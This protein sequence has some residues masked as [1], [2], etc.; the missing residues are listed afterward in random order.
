MIKKYLEYIK[1][2]KEEKDFSGKYQELKDKV[3]SFIQDTVDEE[4][5]Y[6]SVD[7]FIDSYVKKEDIDIR[8]LIKQDDL[9]QFYLDWRNDID[10]ILNSINFFDEV[11]SKL[12]SIGL[13]DYIITGTKKAISEVVRML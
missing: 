1:E 3:K 10:E 11:P 13:Y 2:E 9:Y 4:K 8:G 12:N 5:Q 7:S 6:D